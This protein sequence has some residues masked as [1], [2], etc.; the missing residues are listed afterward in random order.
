MT[1]LVSRL[2]YQ[3]YYGQ[4]PGDKAVCHHCDEP[5][6]CN[7]N[8]LFLGTQADNLSDMRSKGRQAR[9]QKNGASK[10]TEGDVLII[11]SL[12]GRYT[13]AELGQMFRVSGR[14]VNY[15]L[16]GKNWSHVTGRFSK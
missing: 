10:L 5:L 9:G 14:A 2:V 15:I 4:A 12:E 6:C 8:H 13:Q 11:L 7:P 16:R 3:K 1:Y